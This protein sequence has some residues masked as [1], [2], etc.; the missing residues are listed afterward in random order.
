MTPRKPFSRRRNECLATAGKAIAGNEDALKFG[1]D[2][3]LRDALVGG[4]Q[5][6][7][8]VQRPDA[9][10]SVGWDRHSLMTRIFRLQDYMAADLVH[11]GVTPVLAQVLRK[12]IPGEISRQLHRRDEGSLGEGKAL[13]ADQMQPDTAGSRI[14]GIKEVSTH[15]FI[16]CST[17]RR[18]V[19][20]LSH[21]RLREAL[22]DIAAIRFLRHLKDQ[23]LHL[24]IYSLLFGLNQPRTS[25]AMLHHSSASLRLSAN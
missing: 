7:D 9:Q 20:T 10:K 13:V 5:P 24:I 1:K 25:F 16:D 11:D 12:I 3:F 23:L 8:R 14:E 6:Q 15:G 4:Y 17:H 22:G 21:D 19:I 18:P 2:L